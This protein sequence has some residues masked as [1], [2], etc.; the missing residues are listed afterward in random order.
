MLSFLP[1]QE[2]KRIRRMYYKRVATVVAIVLVVVSI[3]GLIALIPSYYLAQNKKAVLEQEFSAFMET[4]SLENETDPRAV[5]SAMRTRMRVLHGLPESTLLSNVSVMLEE[6]TNGIAITEIRYARADG[7][8]AQFVVKGVA[9]TRDELVAYQEALADR[10]VFSAVELPISF[11]AHDTDV[12]FQ[13]T[14]D[15]V[16]E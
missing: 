9:R 16:E 7:D 2:Q 3:V 15:E 6:T 4:G 13:I 5:L 1:L 10:E 8:R 12:D 11:L 14:I